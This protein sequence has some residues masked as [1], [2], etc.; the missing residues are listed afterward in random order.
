[1]TGDVP[2]SDSLRRRLLILGL[3]SVPVYVAIL[4]LSY[5]FAPGGATPPLL[6]VLALLGLATVG[7]WLALG[8]ALGQVSERGKPPAR[9][10]DHLALPSGGSP[11]RLADPTL[12]IVLFFAVG[13]RLLLLPSWP[14]QEADFYRYLWDGR[15]T[16]HG[17]N[18]YHYSPHQVEDLG[19]RTEPGTEL[20]TLWQLSQQSEAVHTIFERVH[21]RGV[22]TV[23]PPVAQLVFAVTALL[24]PAASPVWAHI[25]VLK[26]VLLAF[27]LATLAVLVLL[28]RQLR[29]PAVWCLAYGWCPLVMKEF[30]N[31]GHLDAIAIFFTTI[32]LYLLVRWASSGAFLAMLTLA[33]AV[34]AKSYPIVLFPVVAA[35]LLARLGSRAVIPLAGFPAVVVAGYLPFC[36]LGAS[37]PAAVL[38]EE[39]TDLPETSHAGTGLTTFL[40]EWE[41]ND[42]L[43][44]LVGE[45][46]RPPTSGTDRWFVVLPRPWRAELHAGVLARLQ[47]VLPPKASAAFVLTQAIMGLVLL[48]LTLRWAWGVYRRPEPLGLLRAAFLTLVWG[49]LLSSTQNPWYLLWSLPLMLFAGRRSWFLLPGP[50]LLYYLRFWMDG[51]PSGTLDAFDYGVVWLEYGPFFLA[52]LGE[53][54]FGRL[55]RSG[56]RPDRKQWMEKLCMIRGRVVRAILGVVIVLSVGAVV[57]HYAKPRVRLGGPAATLRVSLAE[58][59]HAPFDRLLQKYVDEE[60]LVAYRRWKATPE[61]MQTLD[62][63]LTRLG[64]VDRQLPSSR[65]AQLAFWINA[66]NALT[67]KGILREYPTSTIRNHTSYVPGNYNM[68][69]DLLLRIDDRDVSLDDIEHQILR[70]MGEPRIHFALVCAAKG[71]P[72]LRRRVYTADGLEE[73]LSDNA[74]RFFARPTNFEADA[75]SRTV[76]LSELLDWYGSDFARTPAEQ[77]RWLRPYFPA[78]ERLGWLD[79]GEITV[80]YLTYDWSL[81]DQEDP[82]P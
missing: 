26:T 54:W 38:E 61:D 46:L 42:F 79:A 24:T 34:L 32:S 19:P 52:L 27:D 25:L 81:N 82:F 14:I 7:Y 29:L 56:L 67:I 31:S 68:W 35:Y 57:A 80:K 75:G 69:T 4:L 36:S 13:F 28:L 21:Y 70:K 71:C 37:L 39:L 11:P 23:Y 18:P 30:A 60:G 50:V 10:A 40:T 5:Q 49:W 73:Q 63:Y 65:P 43:F 6:W 59:N 33:L 41:M 66:Y 22:P 72:P 16:L 53:S 78:P 74:R 45:N 15:V 20:A 3:A 2:A 62:E 1:M 51:S 17:H 77:V 8:C 64:A 55:R 47:E 12:R 48:G 9:D 44:M 76:S 58:V